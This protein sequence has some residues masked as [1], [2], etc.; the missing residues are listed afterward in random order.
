MSWWYEHDGEVVGP[1][2][3]NE[4]LSTIEAGELSKNTLVWCGGMG[5]WWQYNDLVSEFGEDVLAWSADNMAEFDDDDFPEITTTSKSFN[6]IAVISNDDVQYSAPEQKNER[7]EQSYPLVDLVG[8]NT[9]R[10]KH[11]LMNLHKKTISQKSTTKVRNQHQLSAEEEVD[12]AIKRAILKVIAVLLSLGLL[13]QGVSHI[14]NDAGNAL[15]VVIGYLITAAIIIALIYGAVI[16]MVDFTKSVLLKLQKHAGIIF[17]VGYF[18]LSIAYFRFSY[19][20]MEQYVGAAWSSVIIAAT[21]LFNVPFV[22]TVAS[23]IYFNQVSG[24]NVFVSA[25]FAMPLL[26][27]YFICLATGYSTSIFKWFSKKH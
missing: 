15:G 9:S 2:D 6:K 18:A 1:I 24:F 20:G 10:N 25:A 12:K 17:I 14:N 21:I 5:C 27:F 13:I 19:L 16:T 7:I 26:A 22:M 11:N 8:D 4:L 3:H 23:F